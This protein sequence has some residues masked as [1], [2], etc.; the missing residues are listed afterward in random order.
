M[1][2]FVNLLKNG[3]FALEQGGGI[4]VRALVEH[5]GAVE[6]RGVRFGY[7][8]AAPVLEGFDLDLVPGQS[9]ALGDGPAAVAFRPRP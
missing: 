3:V 8:P 9:V 6:F 1:Q 7:D 5:A 4:T 2:V